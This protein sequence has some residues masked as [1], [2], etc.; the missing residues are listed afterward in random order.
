M[1]YFLIPTNIKTAYGEKY[2]L[3][4]LG[5]FTIGFLAIHIVISPSEK[6]SSP[7]TVHE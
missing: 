5:I 6:P 2:S 7:I 4:F 3:L 1:I